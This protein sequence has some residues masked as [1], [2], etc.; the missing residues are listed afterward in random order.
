MVYHESGARVI[1]AERARPRQ[2]AVREILVGSP[3]PPADSGPNVFEC[4]RAT[5]FW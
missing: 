4:A 5:W 1:L 2:D 3:S